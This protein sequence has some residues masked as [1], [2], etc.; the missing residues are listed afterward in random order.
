METNEDTNVNAITVVQ[1]DRD[2][3]Y[4][5]LLPYAENWVHQIELQGLKEGLADDADAVQFAAR[6]RTTSLAAQDGLVDALRKIAD[7]A[8]PYTTG[9]G[10]QECRQIALA[11]LASIEVKS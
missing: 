5:I 10:H 2:L 1:A 11:A 4:D 3:V 8:V 6:H 7:S 9:E